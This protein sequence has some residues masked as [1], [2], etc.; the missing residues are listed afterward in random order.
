VQILRDCLL[1]GVLSMPFLGCGSEAPPT[2]T[3]KPPTRTDHLEAMSAAEST[4]PSTPAAAPVVETGTIR[5]R[6]VF[7]GVRPA[8]RVLVAQGKAAQDTEVCAAH[9]DIL[10]EDLIVSESGGLANVFVYLDRAP[11]NASLPPMPKEAIP[12]DQKACVFTTHAVIVRTNQAVKVLS[13]DEIAHNVHTFP[14]R[15]NSFNQTL[16]PK[17]RKGVDL[18]YARPETEPVEVK[19]DMHTWMRAW[20]L[21]LDHPFGAVTAPDGTFRIEGLP[22]GKHKFRIWHER[23][24]GGFL[25][26]AYEVDV[27]PGENDLGDIRFSAS[28][29]GL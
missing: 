10:S 15:N 12:F 20:H 5:G 6:I 14:K 1:F 2:V 7:D 19:C 16:A 28:R 11:P 26:R 8:P 27:Q 24:P 22:V 3:V 4:Q 25:D 21:P 29:F 13:D 9:S 23:V 18:V 17:D